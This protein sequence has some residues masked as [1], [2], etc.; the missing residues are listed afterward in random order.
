MDRSSGRRQ[1]AQSKKSA[2]NGSAASTHKQRCNVAAST[3]G[4][5][6]G[7]AC[8]SRSSVTRGREG[9]VTDSRGHYASNALASIVHQRRSTLR[10]NR[11]L[12]EA[13]EVIVLAKWTEFEHT[14]AAHPR[15]SVRPNPFLAHRLRCH[16]ASTNW[17]CRTFA[18][19]TGAH[20]AQLH[21]EAKGCS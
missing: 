16:V 19:G 9:R 18:I 15:L 6:T 1:T 13:A 7:P 8:R 14:R 3:P 21:A 4:Q 12:V 2:V 10:Y 11:P 5:E 20:G 17:N